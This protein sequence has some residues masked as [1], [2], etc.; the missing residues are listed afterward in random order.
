ME[1]QKHL[2]LIRSRL[3]LEFLQIDTDQRMASKTFLG[4]NYRA[5]VK[6]NSDPNLGIC[7]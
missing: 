4:D 2:S 7:L 5:D 6:R 1:L 3:I